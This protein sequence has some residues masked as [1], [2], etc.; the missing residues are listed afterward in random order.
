MESN[1]FVLSDFN[2][3]IFFIVSLS[4]KILTLFLA[5]LAHL[6]NLPRTPCMAKEIHYM[7]CSFAYKKIIHYICGNKI[8]LYICNMYTELS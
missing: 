2:V 3:T 6:P 7:D 1:P 5:H 4:K 8:F